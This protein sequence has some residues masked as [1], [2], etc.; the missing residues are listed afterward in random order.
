MITLKVKKA[1]SIPQKILGLIGRTSPES[2]FFHT[3]FGIHTFGM[4][5]PL[6][7][8]VLNSKYQ[9]VSIKESLTPYNFFFWNPKYNF[10]LELPSGTV[11]SKK[12]K[13]GSQVKLSFLS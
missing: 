1:K 10:V 4:R 2:L 6:D 13:L 12:I 8:L 5:I 3:R 7:I 9:V 11:K